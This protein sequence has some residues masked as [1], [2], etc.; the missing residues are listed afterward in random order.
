[1]DLSEFSTPAVQ[2]ASEGFSSTL[3]SKQL[4]ENLQDAMATASTAILAENRVGASD[5]NRPA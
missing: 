2:R 5:K 1:M 3:G 4:R